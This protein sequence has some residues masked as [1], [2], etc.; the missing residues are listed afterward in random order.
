MVSIVVAG[1]VGVL[2]IEVVDAAV[3][4][5][6]YMVVGTAGVA[7]GE[8]VGKVVGEVWEEKKKGVDYLGSH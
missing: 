4:G 3:D 2:A 5:V 1:A 6:V 7:V 8:V